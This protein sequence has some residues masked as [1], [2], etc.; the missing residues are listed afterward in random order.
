MKLLDLINEG[1][2]DYTKLETFYNFHR[3]GKFKYN[4]V[5]LRDLGQLPPVE[6][7]Y[8]L[9]PFSELRIVDSD[10]QDKV[11]ID[12]MYK[13]IKVKPLTA[14][15]L[16]ILQTDHGREACI[17]KIMEYFEKLFK[18]RDINFSWGY[19]KLHLIRTDEPL[20]E[21]TPSWGRNNKKGETIFKFLKKGTFDVSFHISHLDMNPEIRKFAYVL[22]DSHR[23]Y[24][25]G[26]NTVIIFCNNVEIKSLEPEVMNNRVSM[27]V[28]LKKVKKIF[29]RYNI[30]I[31]IQTTSGDVY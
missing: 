30:N 12:Y 25:P 14:F 4:V 3:K 23:I 24:Q 15:S 22:S 5:F 16:E 18:K 6:I 27:E 7:E 28:A 29:R 31:E 9:L 20:M 10:A 19:D 11:F 8:E 17:D 26:E 2:Q 13:Q 21:S 1:P